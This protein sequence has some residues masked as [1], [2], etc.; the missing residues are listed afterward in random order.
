MTQG[1]PPATVSRVH[2]A[3][4]GSWIVIGQIASVTGALVLVR[5]LTE[6]LDPAQYGQLALGLSVAGLVNQV[7]T[8]GITAGIARFYSIAAEKQDL[9]GYLRDSRRLLGY[10]VLIVAAIG[11]ALGA[12]LL[13]LG[14]SEWIDLAAAA[15]AFSVVSAFNL[16]IN[17][18]QNAARQRSIVAFHGGLDAWMKIL[19]A[20]GA[21]LWLGTSSTA[22]VIGYT[23]SCVLVTVSQHLFL[24]K[25]IPP[26]RG[27][28]ATGRPWLGQ[29]WAYSW[30]FSAWGIFTWMQQVSDRWGLA[31]FA[32]TDEVGRYAVLFQLGYAPLT[33]ATGLVLSFL[34]PI[35]YQQ[36]GDAT[37]RARN[38]S[39]HRLSWRFMSISLMLTVIAFMITFI[40][41]RSIF[42]LLVASQYR[43]IS[44]LLP[45]VVLAGGLFGSGQMLALKLMSELKSAKMTPAKIV[46]ALLGVTFNIYGAAV[47]GL[48]GVVAALI[49]FSTVYL[50]WMMSLSRARDARG[51]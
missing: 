36:S 51:T 2:L 1:Q 7:V 4:E 12:G 16:S 47:A 21:L 22:V 31:V 34:G 19:L 26:Q 8:G 18:I 6:Y 46:T 37:D 13:L 45:W 10:A 39:V 40:M 11:L 23:F 27:R 17:G 32:T 49:A 50:A 33:M 25:T 9:Q 38:A 30:P 15:L 29:I 3:R 5:V 44:Y 14:Y 42:R 35:L 41:H 28:A 48:P 24:R 43:H 20:M